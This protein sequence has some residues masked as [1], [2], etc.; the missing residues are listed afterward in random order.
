M[1]EFSRKS[2]NRAEDL[3]RQK[4]ALRQQLKAVEAAQKN[5]AAGAAAVKSGSMSGRFARFLRMLARRAFGRKKTTS[6]SEPEGLNIIE[7]SPLFSETFYLNTYPDVK[8]SPL[9]P[10]QHYLRFGG[11]EGRNPSERFD[12]EA[13]LNANTD[14]KEQGI[15]PLLHFERFGRSES[16]PLTPKV[17]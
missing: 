5:Q 12:S 4:N 2:N 10:A 17:K 7:A 8:S 14:V 16:R 15:N 11:F 3:K 9:S 13:Y 6:K 1:E